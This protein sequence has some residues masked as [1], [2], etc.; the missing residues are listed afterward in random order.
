[1]GSAS[2]GRSTMNGVAVI[3][4]FNPPFNY[5]SFD[6]LNSL[7][8]RFDQA[9]RRD[10]IKAIVVTG[11]KGKFSGGFDITAYVDQLKPGFIS[12]EI[13]TDTVEGNAAVL[14]PFMIANI[15]AKIALLLP[16]DDLALGGGLEVTI[17]SE[18]QR[19]HSI[20]QEQPWKQATNLKHSLVC[21]GVLEEGVVSGHWCGLS[22]VLEADE[23]QLLVRSDASKSLVHIFFAQ[24]WNYKGSRAVSLME[25]LII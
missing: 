4:I 25:S 21:S 15:F 23:F 12:V 9:L 13:L 19:R 10:D 3:T 1:M 8:D 20:L 18:K 24:T 2:K 11:V 22:V 7:Q 14:F 5:L 17:L 16:I 6:V